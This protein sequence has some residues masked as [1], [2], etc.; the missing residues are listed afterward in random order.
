MGVT[1]GSTLGGTQG[2][3]AKTKFLKWFHTLTPRQGPSA[4]EPEL[5]RIT[6]S[7]CALPACLP[8]ST[9]T[10]VLPKFVLVT[11]KGKSLLLSLDTPPF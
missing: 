4:D 5:P 3:D 2:R 6:A 7:R 10:V 1:L 9:S 11:T 8:Y